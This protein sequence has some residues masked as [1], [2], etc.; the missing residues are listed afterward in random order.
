MKELEVLQN[1]PCVIAIHDF[2][3]GGMGHLTYDGQPLNFEFV[4]DALH[5]VY[6]SFHYYV[7]TRETSETTTKEMI[8]NG[9]VPNLVLDDGTK[10]SIDFTWRSEMQCYRGIL[11]CTPTELDLNKF[12]LFKLEA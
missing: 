7:N 6:P 10:D 11:Y 9:E 1:T 3:C 12:E 5:K 8:Q 2:D 4:R